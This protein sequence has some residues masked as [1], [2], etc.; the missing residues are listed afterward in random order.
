[1]AKKPKVTK[2]Q[3]K[4]N[5]FELSSQ[6]AHSYF[7]VDS[8]LDRFGD[9]MAG[10]GVIL[11]LDALG[12]SCTNPVLIRDGLSK[13]TIKAIKADLARSYLLAVQLKPSG[14]KGSRE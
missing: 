3:L 11:R 2:E 4:R 9:A 6:L 14:A 1:M 10:G 5:I 12:G 8:Q 7:A 13:E